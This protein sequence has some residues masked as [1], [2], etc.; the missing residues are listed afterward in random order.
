[1]L[2]SFES[3]FIESRDKLKDE[4]SERS[5][6]ELAQK[7]EANYS[8]IRSLILEQEKSKDN[9]T[10]KELDIGNIGT[11]SFA[12]S[13]YYNDDLDDIPI[14]I[15]ELIPTISPVRLDLMSITNQQL[16]E[17]SSCIR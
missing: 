17:G 3:T 14:R 2:I 1:M 6:I 15:R 13:I 12:F 5:K 11:R 16:F 10:P 7:L 9:S 8:K 4:F